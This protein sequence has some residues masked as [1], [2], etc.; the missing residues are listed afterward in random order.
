MLRCNPKLSES[1]VK[2]LNREQDSADF[3]DGIPSG[4]FGRISDDDL[5]AVMHKVKT[6]MPWVPPGWR[7]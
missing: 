1:R 7:L 6:G 3:Q 2:D 5:E 4:S